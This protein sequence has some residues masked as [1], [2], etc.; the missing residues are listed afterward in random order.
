[1]SSSQ[2]QVQERSGANVPNWDTW[3]VTGYS[4]R[5]YNRMMEHA[6]HGTY[7]ILFM[8]LDREDGDAI[9]DSFNDPVDDLAQ[10]MVN[11]NLRDKRPEYAVI[12]KLIQQNDELR[13]GELAYARDDL[14]DMRERAERAER[15]L[16]KMQDKYQDEMDRSDWYKK[17]VDELE[18]LSDRHRE[19][20]AGM[21]RTL[22]Y[23]KEVIEE[24][25]EEYGYL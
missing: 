3:K 1:M 25:E 12:A 16:E 19:N 9:I 10:D 21:Q 14:K 2:Q 22:Q 18:L 7:T 17:R 13:R 8:D 11:M 6:E 23:R 5:Y 4:N 15:E 24:Y 20:I